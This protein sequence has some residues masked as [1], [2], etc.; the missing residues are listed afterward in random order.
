M[1]DPY[2]RPSSN[3][4]VPSS[5]TVPM[6]DVPHN[7]INNQFHTGNM[8][9]NTARS[10]SNN[11]GYIPPSSTTSR[12]N[13][14][15]VPPAVV[16]TGT[17]SSVPSSSTTEQMSVEWHDLVNRLSST[18][19]SIKLYTLDELIRLTVAVPH[20]DGRL[21]SSRIADYML[22]K[23]KLLD[24]LV[25]LIASAAGSSSQ[26]IAPD[27]LLLEKALHVLNASSWLCWEDRHKSELLAGYPSLID[28]LAYVIMRGSIDC[29]AYAARCLWNIAWKNEN[30]RNNHSSILLLLPILISNLSSKHLYLKKYSLGL[31]W[32]LC[33]GNT[34]K[35]RSISTQIIE[36]HEGTKLVV[37]GLFNSNELSAKDGGGGADSETYFLLLSLLAT[38]LGPQQPAQR[39]SKSDAQNNNATSILLSLL[40]R[41]TSSTLMDRIC[42]VLTI[43]LFNQ[44]REQKTFT[45]S[46]GIKKLVDAL[47]NPV[48]AKAYGRMQI[49]LI[50]ALYRNPYWVGTNPGS[51]NGINATVAQQQLH[52]KWQQNEM[53]HAQKEKRSEQIIPTLMDTVL[54]IFHPLSARLREM[55]LTAPCGVPALT[56]ALCLATLAQGVPSLQEILMNSGTLAAMARLLIPFS[57]PIDT[58]Y[59]IQT[60][61]LVLLLQVAQGYP[62]IQHYLVTESWSNTTQNT[63]QQLPPGVSSVSAT[64]QLSAA[65]QGKGYGTI[66]QS[67]LACLRFGHPVPAGSV[68]P[69]KDATLR[70]HV[71]KL[72]TCICE[73]ER[74]ISA[75]LLSNHEN[76]L[77]AI[78]ESLKVQYPNKQLPTMRDDTPLI[79]LAS[80][81]F[82]LGQGPA[83]LA[84]PMPP[85]TST[86]SPASSTTAAKLRDPSNAEALANFQKIAQM[87]HDDSVL[88]EVLLKIHKQ[89]QSL[90]HQQQVAAQAAAAAQVAHTHHT[91]GSSSSTSGQQHHHSSVPNSTSS[92]SNN[93]HGP[94]TSAGQGSG[95]TSQVSAAIQRSLQALPPSMPPIQQNAMQANTTVAPPT[96]Q[97]QQQ[98]QQQHQLASQVHQQQQQFNNALALLAA[99]QIPYPSPPPPFPTGVLPRPAGS[100]VPL[101]GSSTTGGALPL[102]FNA[103]ALAHMHQQAAAVAA[104]NAAVAS[105]RQLTDTEKLMLVYQ[106][107]LRK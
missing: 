63:Q 101:A 44:G 53:N 45:E 33:E 87:M 49:A 47:L 92:T 107:Q 80:C 50:A 10:G 89:V 59:S 77:T 38:L 68:L 62:R 67:I 57:H 52:Q 75:L 73:R 34:E 72:I 94:S 5:S 106:Q 66:F 58:Q 100:P 4:Y 54:R 2:N 56:A 20:S 70:V 36:K 7:A 48:L 8:T 16:S 84:S 97:Q 40:A 31:L 29:S 9:H 28:R 55:S 83:V 61:G 27:H 104:V 35:A 98:Q 18:D 93:P 39:K 96:I 64:P 65:A 37:Q 32:A 81:L 85:P 1:S 79:Q 95:L 25:P 74:S 91:S 88:S 46:N 103:A 21:N 11:T 3:A 43:V 105:P 41:T 76:F 78:F 17:G 99:Q 24:K 6:T 51:V 19:R 69:T 13:V 90:A 82:V 71:A 30:V 102:H 42:E 22:A 15:A 23:C 60:L 26:Q 86:T 14:S 12:S